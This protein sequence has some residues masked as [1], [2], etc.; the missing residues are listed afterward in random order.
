MLFFF[1]TSLQ[2]FLKQSLKVIVFRCANRHLNT[3]MPN[4]VG[5]VSVLK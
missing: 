2:I 4:V 5:P 3:E 1:K